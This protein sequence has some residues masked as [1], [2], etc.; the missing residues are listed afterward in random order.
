MPVITGLLEHSVRESDLAQC[1]PDTSR[2]QLCS[3]QE[4]RPRQ[5][6]TRPLDGETQIRGGC[7]FPSLPLTWESQDPGK[8]VYVIG[9]FG[10]AYLCSNARA[11][12]SHCT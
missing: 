12:C 1:E 7:F 5:Y 6:L 2:K 11:S 4:V 3:A 9:N 8:K 10:P